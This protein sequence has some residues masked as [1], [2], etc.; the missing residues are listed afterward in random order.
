MVYKNFTKPS[1][2]MNLSMHEIYKMQHEQDNDLYIDDNEKDLVEKNNDARE[3]DEYINNITENFNNHNKNIINRNKMLENVK[4]GLLAECFMKLYKASSLTP[5]TE[6]DT[7]VVKNIIN[8]FI[9]ERC[10]EL[11]NDFST[12]NYILSEFSRITTKYYN[13]VL[14]NSEECKEINSPEQLNNICVDQDVLNGFYKELE[15]VD[16][17]DASKMIKD[18]VSDSISEFIDTNIENKLEYEDIIKAAQDKMATS[19]GDQELVEAYS[20]QAKRNI[21]ERK[22]KKRNNVFGF[23]VESLTKSAFKDENLKTRYF[24]EAASINMESVV[25]SVQLL[26]TMLEMVNTTN[27][28][29]VDDKFINWY[30][31]N[32]V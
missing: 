1:K 11:I 19:N 5:L 26:Y 32:L 24:N 4:K 20:M 31:T 18:R 29:N 21:N 16:I 23:M 2:N 7:I 17:D 22:L 6:S 9:N 12:K 30:L 25:H 28:V 13:K 14:E 27:M 8:K 10:G 15:D 3:R